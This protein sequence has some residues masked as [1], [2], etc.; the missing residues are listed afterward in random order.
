MWMLFGFHLS[1]VSCASSSAKTY[2]LHL[3]G[4]LQHMT[5]MP[6]S[7]HLSSVLPLALV[8]SEPLSAHLS[9]ALP[10]ALVLSE[11]KSPPMLRKPLHD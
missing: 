3:F 4:N 1:C 5:S 11:P 6:L 9:S 7:A 2:L 8:L 10:L